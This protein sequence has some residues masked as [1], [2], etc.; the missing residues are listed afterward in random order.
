MSKKNNSFRVFIDSNVL[1][2][3]IRSQNS[4]SSKLLNLV[5]TEHRLVICT[6]TIIEVS[7]VKN[8]IEKGV[9]HFCTPLIKAYRKSM[10]K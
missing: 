6:Y 2:S 8:L 9:F 1:I 10:M 4:V 3:A 7:R 5:I